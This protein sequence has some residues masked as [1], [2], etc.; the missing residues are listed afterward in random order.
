MHR[1]ECPRAG[2]IRF[3]EDLRELLDIRERCQAHP[4]VDEAPR[5][6]LRDSL[7][8]TVQHRDPGA[9]KMLVVPGEVGFDLPEL[10][11]RLAD[12]TL[13]GPHQVG[14]CLDHN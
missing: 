3:G 1:S 5:E 7:A 10:F 2:S 12:A 6:N 4:R 13:S 11:H 9:I 14:G 8:L